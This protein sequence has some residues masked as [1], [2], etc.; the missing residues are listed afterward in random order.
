MQ[1]GSEYE[2]Y[3][4]EAKINNLRTKEGLLDHRFTDQHN[5]SAV[6]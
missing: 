6:S 3:V 5:P 1:D 4:P 2:K